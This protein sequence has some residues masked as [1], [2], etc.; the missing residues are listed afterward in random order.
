MYSSLAIELAFD[1]FTGGRRSETFFTPGK[2][3]VSLCENFHTQFIM[4]S[5]D[6]YTVTIWVW[7]IF[8]VE[9]FSWCEGSFAEFLKSQ[10]AT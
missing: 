10:L 4:Y 6:M 3:Q 7:W 8:S 2:F 5:E 1:N 9:K